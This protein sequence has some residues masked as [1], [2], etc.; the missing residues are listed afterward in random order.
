MHCDGLFT[1]DREDNEAQTL[2]TDHWFLNT[3]AEIET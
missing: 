2:I 1:E 3:K